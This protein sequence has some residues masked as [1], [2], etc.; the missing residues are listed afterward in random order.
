LV[1]DGEKLDDNADTAVF[2]KRKESKMT[3]EERS[4]RCPAII[5]KILKVLEDENVTIADAEDILKNV[6]WLTLDYLHDLGKT[7]TV[8]IPKEIDWTWFYVPIAK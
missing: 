8:K 4:Q 3:N 7:T 1:E 6:Q 2:N 5:I